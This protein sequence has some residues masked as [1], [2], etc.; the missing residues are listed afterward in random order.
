MASKTYDIIFISMTDP[1]TDAR[2]LNLINYLSSIGKSILYVAVASS[3][4]DLPKGVEFLPVPMQSQRV[5]KQIVEF[6]KKISGLDIKGKYIWASDL[7]VLP[8]ASLVAKKSKAKLIY[9]SREIYSALGPL[10][11]QPLKQMVITFLEKYYVRFVDHFV[12]SGDLDAKYL[13]KHFRTNKPF[14]LVMNLPYSKER[15]DSNIIREN[16][17]LPAESK[18]ILYQGMILKGRGLLPVLNSLDYLEHTYLAIA[19]E[20]AY[21]AEFEQI[22]KSKNL[23]DRVVFIGKIDYQDLHNWTCSADIGIVYIEPISFSYELALPNKLFEY[24]MAELPSLVSDLPAMRQILEEFSI[25][26]L[27]SINASNEQFAEKCRLLLNNSAKYKSEC[28][29]AA[30]KYNYAAQH[31][32]ISEIFK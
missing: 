26:E 11:G 6:K 27:L 23:Q 8:A 14:S 19:G 10:A 31:T 15:I 5:Y 9:D 29:K 28:K 25:G 7:Y 13:I 17:K 12:V 30:L 3:Q 16:F 24:A 22:I 4:P 2:T 18:I 21:K 20:G 1:V 32:T